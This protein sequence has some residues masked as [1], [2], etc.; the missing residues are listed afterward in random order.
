MLAGD[1]AAC[2]ARTASKSCGR[3]GLTSTVLPSVSS[4]YVA[5]TGVLT[6]RP[7]RL[8]ARQRQGIADTRSSSGSPIRAPDASRAGRAPSHDENAAP[9]RR[10]L[11]QH[12]TAI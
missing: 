2:I 8:T 3:A 11:R 12:Q 4:A 5:A 6:G 10:D 9:R 1:I 7:L